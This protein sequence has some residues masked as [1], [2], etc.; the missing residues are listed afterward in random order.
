M[1]HYSITLPTCS[2]SVTPSAL[3][4]RV[5]LAAFCEQSGPPQRH[6]GGLRVSDDTVS[7]PAG[8]AGVNTCGWTSSLRRAPGGRICPPVLS[9]VGRCS[10]R[11]SAAHHRDR[12]GGGSSARPVRALVRRGIHSDPHG[13]FTAT[14]GIHSSSEIERRH[15]TGGAGSCSMHGRTHRGRCVLGPLTLT[16]NAFMPGHWPISPH[17]LRPAGSLRFSRT[18]LRIRCDAEQPIPPL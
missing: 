12:C 3:S 6:M 13:A 1:I 5:P 10:I 15:H 8:P 7:V 16:V 11:C 14:M 2:W 17:A 18:Y 4:T 9:T